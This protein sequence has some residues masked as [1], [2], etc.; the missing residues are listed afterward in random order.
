MHIRSKKV[1]AAY[2]A[3]FLVLVLAEVLIAL[4]VHD[5]IIR[6]YVGDVIV[7]PVLYCFVRTI[8]PF[9]V[10][11]LPL[12]LFLLAA[13]IEVG[14]YFH[15]AALLGVDDILFFQIILGT[16]FSFVDILCYAAGGALCFAAEY[17]RNR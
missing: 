14:Q 17:L 2:L 15:Y 11:L 9:G 3:T 10:R 6:P 13:L 4:F 12:Y 16:S 7:I 5:R 8:M 1:R